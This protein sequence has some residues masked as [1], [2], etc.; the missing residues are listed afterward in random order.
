MFAAERIA[1][2]SII[3]SIREGGDEGQKF[4]SNALPNWNT[5][6]S[7]NIWVVNK[8]EIATSKL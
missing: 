8:T 1:E 6:T 3:V 7:L 4:K 2:V 5:R